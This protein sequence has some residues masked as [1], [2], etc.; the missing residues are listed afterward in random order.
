[1]KPT[2]EP[3]GHGAIGTA[4]PTSD[5]AVQDGGSAPTR[6]PGSDRGGAWDRQALERR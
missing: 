5:G 2:D 6:E 4:P 3:T 1:M